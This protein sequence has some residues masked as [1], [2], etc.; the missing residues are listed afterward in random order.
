VDRLLDNAEVILM[1]ESWCND[2]IKE[3]VVR[4]GGNMQDRM[5][6][7]RSVK[8]QPGLREDSSRCVI[9]RTLADA[10]HAPSHVGG[11]VTQVWLYGPGVEPWTIQNPQ[12]VEEFI[13]RFDRGD[14]PELDIQSDEYRRRMEWQ[15]R[16]KQRREWEINQ[17]KVNSDKWVGAPEIK[18]TCDIP[19][20]PLWTQ[21]SKPTKEVESEGV[22]ASEAL[23]AD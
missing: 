10:L 14:M 17:W 5:F 12:V 3:S 20:M 21:I 11:E 4:R 6:R 18:T 2:V 16:D 23:T 1:T 9:A 22:A 13:H 7:V 19:V 8:L 15:E